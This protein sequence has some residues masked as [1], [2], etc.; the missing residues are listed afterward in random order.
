MTGVPPVLITGLLFTLLLTGL[1]Y[2]LWPY[3]RRVF[4]HV[5]LLTA[6]GVLLG[7]GWFWLELPSLHVGDLDLVPGLLFAAALQPLGGRLPLPPG[8]ARRAKPKI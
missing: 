5:L 1:F 3:A 6:A 7:Q 2:G 4:I 8:L